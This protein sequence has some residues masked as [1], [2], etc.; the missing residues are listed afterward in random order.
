[1]A[2]INTSTNTSLPIVPLLQPPSPDIITQ[3]VAFHQSSILHD[4]M[5]TWWTKR[6]STL[7][8]PETHVFLALAPPQTSPFLVSGAA[9]SEGK[10]VG[11]VILSTPES[12]TQHFVGDVQML[13]IDPDFRG[14]GLAKRLMQAVEEQARSLGRTMLTLGTTVGCEAD[15][16]L[17]PKLGWEIYGRLPGYGERPPAE[18]GTGKGE[19]VDG[20]FYFKVLR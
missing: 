20:V 4:R 19:K 1:M 17:Y 5:T 15:A 10:V 2:A 7:P 12:D 13:M 11:I 18:D 14:K 8:S 3:L 6:L 9:A 16:Y